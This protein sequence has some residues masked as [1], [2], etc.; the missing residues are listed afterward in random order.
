M[1]LVRT[2]RLCRTFSFSGARDDRAFR[3]IRNIDLEVNTGECVGLIGR[4]G[5]G[6]TTLLRVL[7]GVLEPDSGEIDVKGSLAALIESAGGIELDV[8]GGENLRNLLV[9]QGVEPKN[10][11]EILE[12]AVSFAELGE[13]LYEPVRT[14]STGMM[15][16]L[17]FAAVI[18]LEADLLLV[19]EVLSVGDPVF[20]R[21][22]A[23]EIRR[24]VG[25]G[26]TIILASH[27]YHEIAALC[28]RV[29][30]MENGEV[31][32]DG[33]SDDVYRAFWQRN[34]DDMSRITPH[35]RPRRADNLLK[36]HAPLAENTGE[37]R[38]THVR[39]CNRHG[40]EVRDF[41]TLTAVTVEIGFDVPK[42]VQ[43]VLCR[44]Q[45]HRSD[46]LFVMGSN[47]ERHGMDLARLE[48][49]GTL[50]L[51]YPHFPLAQGE[52]FVS[53]GLWPDEYRS[54]IAERAYDYHENAYVIGVSQGRAAGG[55][56]VAS[57]HRWTVEH[58]HDE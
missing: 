53:V 39:F 48:G 52:Y 46:G 54:F 33:P 40:M 24:F 20:Q 4:N 51:T 32:I 45:F 13:A 41:E 44:V 29:V 9:L 49:R 18:F 10:L 16:R 23:N 50:R 55:G 30:L 57:E 31:V 47:T 56:L 14:Y 43:N 28:E 26:G 12:R 5:C 35:G 25:D 7:A 38:I 34:E 27:N 1:T 17:A 22:C 36:A 2:V 8:S 6:K 21:R 37:A 11:D 15:M 3:G 42:P 58:G 19:D